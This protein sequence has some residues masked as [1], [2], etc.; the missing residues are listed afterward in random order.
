M[1]IWSAILIFL[2]FIICNLIQLVLIQAY[3]S[4]QEEDLLSKRSQEIQTFILEQSQQENGREMNILL[5]EN[6][7]DKIIGRNEMIRVLDKKGNEIY[8]ISVDLPDIQHASLPRQNGFSSMSL[9]GED[10]LLLKSP[11]KTD[12]FSGFLEIGK[13]IETFDTFMEKVIW[14]LMLGTILSLGLSLLSGRVLAGKLVAPLRELTNT[15]RK[16]EDHQFQERVPEIATKDEFS[17]LSSIFNSMMDKVEESFQQQK[18]FVEDASHELRTPLA[19]IHGHLS[20]LQRWGKN[21]QKILEKSL[22]ISIK[23]TNRMIDLTNELLSLSQITKKLEHCSFTPYPALETLD[24]I[25]ENYQLLYNDLK[26]NRKSN[27]NEEIQLAIPQEQLRQVL[28]IIMD[29]SIKYSGD[30]K[31]ISITTSEENGKWKIA[32]QDNGYGINE[33]DLPYIFDR[34]YRVDKAR[35]RNI[36]GNGLGLSIAKKIIEESNGEIIVESK[37]G[38]GTTV[39]LLLDFAS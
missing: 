34:F 11:I 14:V 7:F 21:D 27:T 36:G 6:F 26:I 37:R 24:E 30:K 2:I 39:I 15:M 16:I 38:K 33:E 29:N 3:T 13:S 8:N 32:I 19:I 35:S 12:S 4:K 31:E 22:N 25:I 20:L 17:Q 18:R 23:E 10:V 1:T 9:E 28:I 5:A